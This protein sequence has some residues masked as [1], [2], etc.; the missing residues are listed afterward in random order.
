VLDAV[1]MEIDG[2][3]E[4]V[5][6]V[7]TVHPSL[8]KAIIHRESAFK[9]RA[10]SRAGAVGLMQVL[11]QNA[12]RLALRAEELWVPGLNI[13]AGTRLLAV[14]FR[15]YRGDVVSALVAY[16]AR[17][18]RIFAPLPEN[19]ETEQYVRAVLKRWRWLERCTASQSSRTSSGTSPRCGATRLFAQY[20]S[21][22]ARRT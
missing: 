20:T 19:G 1:A 18:R 6:R 3:V 4:E 22:R 5:S 21:S 16:N 17:P 13:L 14:L 11:P 2:E 10:L 8:V 9:P 12:E 15:H 7:W